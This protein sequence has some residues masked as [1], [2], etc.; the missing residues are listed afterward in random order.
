MKDFLKTHPGYGNHVG[1]SKTKTVSPEYEIGI[2]N[3]GDASSDLTIFDRLRPLFNI[4]I[5]RDL[6]NPEFQSLL[7]EHKD[8]IILHYVVT[9]WGGTPMEPFTPSIQGSFQ[10]LQNLISQGFP[11][12][13][14]VLRIDP[15]IPNEAGLKAL[16]LVLQLYSRTS[17][18]RVRYK[19]FLHSNELMQRQSWFQVCTFVQNPYYSETH[20]KVFFSAS[21]FQ[22]KAV[23]NILKD[24]EWVFTFE[25]CDRLDVRQTSHATGCISMKDLRIIGIPDI[26]VLET[27]KDNRNCRCP[28]N[29]RELMPNRTTQCA[30]K[31]AH[32][33]KKTLMI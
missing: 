31:C 6:R 9:G 1:V 8:I 13:Q 30:L 19:M 17:I 12:E 4:I 28:I 21:E 25:S 2:N 23:Y 7:L 29:K 33:I 14:V 18:K 16:K 26:D 11:V 32:C 5:T 20:N 10:L 15:I 24:F 27:L 22:R 3:G